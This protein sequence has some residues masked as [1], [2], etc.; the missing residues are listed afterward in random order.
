MKTFFQKLFYIL[1]LPYPL[2]SF[3]NE[4][5]M[6]AR[7]TQELEK[8]IEKQETKEKLKTLCLLQLQKETVP[9]ACYEWKNFSKNPHIQK[10]TLLTSYLN[11]KCEEFSGRLKKPEQIKQ[12]LQK[13]HL[14][15]FCRKQIKRAKKLIEYQLRDQAPENILK[16]HLHDI[17]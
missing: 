14:S 4:Q 3:P 10:N 12:I 6:S 2:L 16:W 1:L 17:P 11:E 15:E 9:Y 13:Q 8:M 7:S 5:W